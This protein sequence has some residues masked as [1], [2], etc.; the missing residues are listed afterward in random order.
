[1]RNDPGQGSNLDGMPGMNND[2]PTPVVS[3]VSGEPEPDTRCGE[4]AMG[5]VHHGVRRSGRG[6]SG[7]A[8]PG[9]VRE[10]KGRVEPRGER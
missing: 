4:Q 10:I 7:G 8:I 9:R 2:L 1:M 3:K 5:S 6:L